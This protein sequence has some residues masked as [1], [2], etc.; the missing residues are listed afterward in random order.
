MKYDI[1]KDDKDKSVAREMMPALEQHPGW[2]FITRAIEA[3]IQFLIDQLKDTDFQ[4]LLEVRLRQKQ[5][6]HLSDLLHLPQTILDAAAPDP[7]EEDP[8]IY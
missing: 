7:E 5:I 8:E 6:T 2:K 3:N 1:F 4:D